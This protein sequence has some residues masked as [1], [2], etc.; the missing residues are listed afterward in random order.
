MVLKSPKYKLPIN[1][2]R[3]IG[4]KNTIVPEVHWMKSFTVTYK[5]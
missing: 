4:K 2:I 5:E 3:E 1:E